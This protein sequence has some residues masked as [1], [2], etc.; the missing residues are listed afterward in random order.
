MIVQDIVYVAMS[1]ILVM[2]VL[3]ITTFMVSRM[4][5]PPEPKII[6]RDVP[7]Q[8]QYVQ[9]PPPNVAQTQQLFAP[10]KLSTQNGPALTQ[11]PPEIQLPEYEPRKPASTSVRMDAELPAGIQETRPE[12]T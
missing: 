11:A 2:A 8:Q 6:Y 9:Q 4:L 1:T 7:V 12:G 10:V 3:Q 5:Y